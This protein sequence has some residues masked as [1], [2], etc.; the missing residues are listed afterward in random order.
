MGRKLTDFPITTIM[1]MESPKTRPDGIGT[2]EQQQNGAVW[3]LENCML[4]F[5][6]N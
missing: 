1:L 4:Q 5:H 6:H 3:R 2:W